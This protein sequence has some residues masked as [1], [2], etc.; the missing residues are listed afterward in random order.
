VIFGRFRRVFIPSGIVAPSKRGSEAD[1]IDADGLDGV[2]DVL[3][4]SVGRWLSWVL[5]SCDRRGRAIR[6]VFFAGSRDGRPVDPPPSSQCPSAI[7]QISP[8][9]FERRIAAAEIATWR[10]AAAHEGTSDADPNAAE[11]VDSLRRRTTIRDQHS[12]PV[13]RIGSGPRRPHSRF[14][15]QSELALH[16]PPSFSISTV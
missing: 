7:G 13:Y 9:A 1:V 16:R 12:Q 8:A 3:V 15:A 4:T 10:S 11:H 14:D 6:V 5:N 2:V